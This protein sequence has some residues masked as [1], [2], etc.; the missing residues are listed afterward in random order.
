M[1]VIAS[2]GQARAARRRRLSLVPS[3]STTMHISWSSS[4]NTSGARETH[5]ALLAH[6]SRLTVIWYGIAGTDEGRGWAVAGGRGPGAIVCRG[7]LTSRIRRSG[8][9]RSWGRS[10][11]LVPGSFAV[12][13]A[14]L[15]LSSLGLLQL[16]ARRPP[17]E[18]SYWHRGGPLPLLYQQTGRVRGRLALARSRSA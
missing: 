12:L 15:L 5:F 7:P 8:R 16:P 1:R 14:S 2:T 18:W 13:L 9:W 10:A 17:A 3:G 4:S 11:R 6:K